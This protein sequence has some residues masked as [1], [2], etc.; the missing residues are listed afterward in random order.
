MAFLCLPSLKHSHLS[1]SGKQLQH[2]KLSFPRSCQHGDRKH[3]KQLQCSFSSAADTHYAGSCSFPRWALIAHRSSYSS[4]HLCIQATSGQVMAQSCS[5]ARVSRPCWRPRGTP[6]LGA[7]GLS[8]T[9]TLATLAALQAT[10]ISAIE[11]ETSLTC[12][13]RWLT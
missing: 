3:P 10:P 11:L 1:W 2:L 4:Q 13:E 8:P 6:R 5:L 9:L 12:V 7:S